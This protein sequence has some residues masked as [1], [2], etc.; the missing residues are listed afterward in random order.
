MAYCFRALK[1]FKTVQPSLW[2]GY[3]AASR[4]GLFGFFYFFIKTK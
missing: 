1:P 2:N 3:F 4:V